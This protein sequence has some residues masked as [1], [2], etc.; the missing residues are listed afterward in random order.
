[1]GQILANAHGIVLTD[2]YAPVDNL[3][4]P[5]SSTNADCKGLGFVKT[6][7]KRLTIPQALIP[8]T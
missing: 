2:N 1:M 8:N 6:E 7:N 5:R 4:V 3:L